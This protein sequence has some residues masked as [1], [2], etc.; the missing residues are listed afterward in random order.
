MNIYICLI[1]AIFQNSECY[2]W[3]AKTE[4]TRLNEDCKVI[5][6]DINW[7]LSKHDTSFK[8]PSMK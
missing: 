7:N 6:T 4:I 1:Q 5:E 3:V 2:Q 8:K